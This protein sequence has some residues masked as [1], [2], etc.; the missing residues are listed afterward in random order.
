MN[1]VADQLREEQRQQLRR[2][3]VS[4]RLALALRLGDDD[5]ELFS[6][7]RNIDRE[8]GSALFRGGRQNGRRP[9]RCFDAAR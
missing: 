4:E 6:R 8:S 9:S 3:T 5:L 2:M 7:A 1:S